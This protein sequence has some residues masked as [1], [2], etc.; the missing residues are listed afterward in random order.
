MAERKTLLIKTILI[1]GFGLC[2]ATWAQ[3][4]SSASEVQTGSSEAVRSATV[5]T[6]HGKIIKVDKAKRL[7]TIEGPEGRRAT[8][9]VENPRNLEA[10]KVGDNVVIRFYEVVS[11]RKKRANENVPTASLKE[12]IS[13]AKPGNLPAAVLEQKLKLLVTV[14]AIDEANGTVTVKAGDGTEETVKARDP[15]NLKRLKVGDELVVTL[16]RAVGISIEKQNS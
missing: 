16:E 2:F 15:K 13:T 11:V 1:V 3:T 5:V 8:V 4:T 10:A 12:G 7:V 14:E 9:L 6:V